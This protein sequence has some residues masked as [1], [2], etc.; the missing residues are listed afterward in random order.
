M[1]VRIIVRGRAAGPVVLSA[2]PINFL[3]AVDK[4][5]GVV[6]D[7]D[8]ELFG[9]SVAGAVLAFPRGAGSSVGA[10]TIYSLGRE[11]AAPAAMV[12]READMTVASGCALADIPLVVAGAAEYESLTDGDMVEV[13]APAGGG[14]GALRHATRRA[15]RRPARPARPLQRFSPRTAPP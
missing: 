3:G 1:T 10:Y 2:A 11:G 6:R 5:T 13:D 8:H 7:R 9:R 14:E 4:R 15:A 12:C